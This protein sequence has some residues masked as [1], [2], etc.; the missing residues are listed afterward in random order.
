MGDDYRRKRS[1][2]NQRAAVRFDEV[3]TSAAND[4]SHA[5]SK[6]NDVW[7][8]APRRVDGTWYIPAMSSG[9][10]PGDTGCPNNYTTIRPPQ[11]GG[12]QLTSSG[13]Q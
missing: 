13:Q 1:D 2:S 5:E 3:D 11:A 9:A 6:S 7:Y 4:R 8:P 12:R 10:Q